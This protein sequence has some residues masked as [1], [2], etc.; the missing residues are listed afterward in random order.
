MQLVFEQI[1]AGGDRN[2]GY[3]LGDRDAK[4]GVLI[5]PSY[6][7]DVFV[8]RARDQGLAVTH[9]INTHGHPDHVNGNERAVELTGAP[10]AAHPTS[11][12]APSVPLSDGQEL[13]VGS[14][15]LRFYHVPGHCDDHV[16]IYE[17]SN[18]ILITG[19]LLFVGK[20]GGTSTEDDARTEWNSLQRL[21]TTIPDEATV[22][23]G[24]DYGVRPASTVALERKTNPFL[25][26]VRLEDFLH[27]KRDWASFKQQHGLK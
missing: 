25:Q 22:W 8:A 26:C 16:L 5:D 7:P 12:A 19:D 14:L 1:R 2:F 18:Q 4:Q 3:L 13:S 11:P 27:L 15:R 17:P 9:I 6:S 24:H 21:L 10:V 23:P 20:V